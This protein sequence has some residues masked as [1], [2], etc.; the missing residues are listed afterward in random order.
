MDAS[1]TESAADQA[2]FS[3]CTRKQIFIGEQCN[4]I[5]SLGRSSLLQMFGQVDECRDPAM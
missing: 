1:G 5:V 3:E 4:T 2:G